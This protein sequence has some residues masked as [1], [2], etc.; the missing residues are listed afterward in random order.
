[1]SA[2]LSS[3]R[4]N[5]AVLSFRRKK[6]RSRCAREGCGGRDYMYSIDTAQDDAES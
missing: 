6:V 3:T 2:W 4:S 5:E 1:M